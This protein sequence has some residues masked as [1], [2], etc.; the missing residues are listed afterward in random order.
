MDTARP[1]QVLSVSDAKPCPFCG[2]QPMIQY[3]HGGGP[4][5]R[6]ISCANDCCKVAP[7]VCGSTRRNA[8]EN[9]NLRP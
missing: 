5:K 3:W 1:E 9:W 7:S 6:L 4:Q 8:L 2:E